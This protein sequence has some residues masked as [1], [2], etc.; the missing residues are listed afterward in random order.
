MSDATSASL[1]LR[2]GAPAVAWSV[3]GLVFLGAACALPF[4]RV[5]KFGQANEGGML[6]GTFSLWA[7]GHWGLA[8]LVAFCGLVAPFGLF[9]AVIAAP[10]WPGALALARRLDPW[11]MPDVRLLAILVAFT[12]LSALVSSLPAAGLACYA[13]AAVC[14]LAATRGL[15]PAPEPVRRPAPGDW[16]KAAALT[17]A[18]GVLLIPAYTLP[19]MSFEK[20]GQAHADTLAASVARLAQAGL[21]GIAAVV[22]VASILVPLLKLAGLAVLIAAARRGRAPT[23]ALARLHRV[24]HSIGRWSMLDVFLVA[25]LCGVVDFGELAQIE[26]RPGVLAFAGAVILTMFA[27]SA[28]ELG[29]PPSRESDSSVPVAP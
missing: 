11:A 16:Q 23:P 18:A 12:K 20:V 19:V 8:L 25:F 3:A 13:A 21:W 24:L 2:P 15:P 9:A 27:T 22:C 29:A 6:S 28:A 7:Q 5:E 1:V 14:A 4:I 26:A 10:H 17:L